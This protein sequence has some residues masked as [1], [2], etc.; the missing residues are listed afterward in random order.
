MFSNQI[1]FVLFMF[2]EEARVER[3]V[4]NFLP[5]GRVLVVDNHSTDRTVEIAKSLGADILLHKNPGWVEDEHTASVVKATVE[6][7]WLYWGF[8]DEIVDYDTM[9]AMLAAIDSGKYA[10]VNVARKNYYY[11]EFCHNAYRN[12]QTR[13]F[14][15]DAVDF[16]GNVIH[17]FGKT[18]VPEA[19]IAY[20]DPDRYFVHH[21]IS[22]TAK[23]YMASLDRYTDIEAPHARP[24]APLAMLL[25][26]ARGFLGHYFLKGGYKAGRAGVY[27]G[28]QTS[29]YLLSL[30][31]KAYEREANL[32]TRTI[33]GRNNEIRD[34]LLLDINA[35]A[36]QRQDGRASL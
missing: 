17:Q 25:R 22:N 18:T 2:N 27:L 30:S 35:H 21:F 11:G 34:K 4:R 13:A 31:M 7:P 36:G 5:F 24:M 23:S 14:K 29:L 10:I 33:E 1:T 3:A 32:T 16:S 19:Q 12:T 26:M 15:K 6:T 28:L 20:L 9:T 8:S